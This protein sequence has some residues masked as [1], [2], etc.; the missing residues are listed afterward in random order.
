MNENRSQV[1]QG[2]AT[3]DEVTE[4]TSVPADILRRGVA[5]GLF[6]GLACAVQGVYWYAPD[7]LPLVA[8]SDRLGNDVVAG[9][10]SRRRAKQMLWARARQLHQRIPL[11]LPMQS[12][13]A[14][15]RAVTNR[16]RLVVPMPEL[17]RLLET[18]TNP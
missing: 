3:E 4:L 16:R 17:T 12:A 15:P 8:W 6:D 1:P 10:L 2:W 9:R 11:S 14:A 7:V 5:A 18:A 13:I